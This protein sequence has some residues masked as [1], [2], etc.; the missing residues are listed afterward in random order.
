MVDRNDTLLREVD[1]ELRREALEKL[2]KRYSNH[3]MVGAAA[4]V[5]AV[6]GYK[7]WETRRNA[8]AE[9]AGASFAAARQL[10]TD[11]K[12]DDGIK[13]L[14]SLADGG[15]RG[16]AALAELQAAGALVK[17]GKN[18]EALAAF[19]KLG[20]RSSA[21][22]LLRDFARLQ[23]AALRL[24]EADFT[25][26]QNWLNDL[27]TDKSPWAA[28]ARELLGTAAFKAGKL[29]EARSA[30]QMLVGD[31]TPPGIAERARLMLSE[32]ATAELAKAGAAAPA[33]PAAAAQPAPAAAQ[34]A[35]AQPPAAAKDAGAPAQAPNK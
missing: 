23:A 34:P 4:I 14:Q 8:A 30:F 24:G 15:P 19:E 32:I 35:T 16:F 17:A 20:K 2:W 22:P 18:A 10:I 27:A 21:D 33:A 12:L 26:M 1:E 31:K 7:A 29:S 11:G 9:N 28:S 25:E 3:I 5:L 6:G 13:A